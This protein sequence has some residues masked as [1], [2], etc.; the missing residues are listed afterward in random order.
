MYPII[1]FNTYVSL[2]AEDMVRISKLQVRG[3]TEYNSK[4][5]FLI[6]QE[7]HVVTPH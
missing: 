2:K 3:G 1:I 5:I 4:I 6:S 7:K